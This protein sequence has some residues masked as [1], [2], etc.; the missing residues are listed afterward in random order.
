MTDKFKIAEMKEQFANKPF[1]SKELYQ[2]YLNYESDLKENTFR[3]RI[4]KLK[5]QGIMTSVKR[6]TYMLE[7]KKI[8]TPPI[9]LG[10][11][12]IYNKIKE[13]F[14]Y[15]EVSIWETNWLAN[16]MVHQPRTDNM[17]IEVDKD[18]MDSV[19]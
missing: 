17:I 11:K 14:P 7:S 6:G 19:F 2:F 4:Y 1:T 16:Y 10:L 18:A 13:Q 8:F 15:I 5:R 9:N 12:R 3:W